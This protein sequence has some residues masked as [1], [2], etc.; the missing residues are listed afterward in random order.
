MNR[1]M[2]NEENAQDIS[3]ITKKTV[4]PNQGLNTLKDYASDNNFRK[5]AEA[6]KKIQKQARK[7]GF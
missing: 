3:H 1:E 4:K 7:Y 5:A 6:L 2:L